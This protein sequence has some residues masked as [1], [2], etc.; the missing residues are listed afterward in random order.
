MPDLAPFQFHTMTVSTIM[1]AHG[2]PWFV[3]VDVCAAL[4][5]KNVSDSL[6]R[7]KSRQID[8][9]VLNDTMGRPQ[10]YKIVNESG[11]YKLAMK[12]RK[13]IAE[14]FQD[15]IAEEVLPQ[16]RKTGAYQAQPKAVDAYP[17]LRAIIQLTEG[18]AEARQQADAAHALAQAA[19]VHAQQA[20]VK[21]E[22]AQEIAREA[23]DAT[24]RMTLEVFILGN[25]LLQ[26]FPGR[27]DAQG[28]RSWPVEGARLTNY[29]RAYG[30]E[31]VRVPVQGK[32]WPSENAYPVQAL[33]WLCRHPV[34]LTQL[35][36]VK[37]RLVN[38]QL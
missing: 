32:P 1:D 23:V 5:I 20:E 3:A 24:G 6:T 29:C 27:L 36:L 7:L 28:R 8:D 10:S 17:E 35:E 19:Q 38:E 2:E 34:N 11:L 18:L 26:Q 31:V 13:K 22:A 15:W 37:G 16:I 4:G 33:A 25:K 14:E 21:A 30:W 12:S 9:I